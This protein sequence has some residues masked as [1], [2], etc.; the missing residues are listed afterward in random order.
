[1]KDNQNGFRFCVTWRA[2]YRGITRRRSRSRGW[3]AGWTECFA[4][5]LLSMACL[6]GS[7]CGGSTGGNA[8]PAS[9]APRAS[10]S[11]TSRPE[12]AQVAAEHNNE[13]VAIP[14]ADGD[15][16]SGSFPFTDV[17]NRLVQAEPKI[18]LVVPY[19]WWH[20]ERIQ[21]VDGIKQGRQN[22]VVDRAAVSV[23]VRVVSF[24]IPLDESATA[25]TV[26]SLLA[27]GKWCRGDVWGGRIEL[28]SGKAPIRDEFVR[29]A[30]AAFKAEHFRD[31]VWQAD[32]DI[33]LRTKQDSKKFSRL[34]VVSDLMIPLP[35]WHLE[36]VSKQFTAFR[37]LSVSESGK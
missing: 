5:A 37:V 21:V 27:N 24:G 13:F 22:V 18:V 11:S 12:D 1:M 34:S 36:S 6:A 17:V 4:F 33:F 15:E 28:E 19:R 3:C 31:G 35:E 16:V 9:K 20:E 23:R 7:G 10:E 2:R 14:E 32:L 30:P 25:S 29:W 26:E 8:N